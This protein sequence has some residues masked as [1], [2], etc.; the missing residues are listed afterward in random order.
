MR[1]NYRA[2]M[3]P[4]SPLILSTGLISRQINYTSEID[5]AFAATRVIFAR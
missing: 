5:S 4:V 1:R 3:K 2:E